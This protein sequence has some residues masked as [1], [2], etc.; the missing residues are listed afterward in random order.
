MSDVRLTALNPDDSS[1]VPVACDAAGKLLL[2]DVP[3]FDGNL[4]GNLTVTGTATVEGFIDT[5]SSYVVH[6]PS[7]A[8]GLAQAFGVYAAG[9]NTCSI[10]LDGSA[11]FKGNT[12]SEYFTGQQDGP[13]SAVFRGTYIGAP[14]AF[15]S[16]IFGDGSAIFAGGNA[17]FDSDGHFWCTTLQGDKV[18]LDTT[19]NG[20]GVWTAYTT[21]KQALLDHLNDIKNP[22]EGST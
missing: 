7:A 5:Y 18:T 15:T 14:I 10:K 22:D 4:T 9:V 19:N 20:Q 16:V 2:Q 13:A 8:T 6:N 12:Q 1:P 3:E 17:G 21:R 11:T